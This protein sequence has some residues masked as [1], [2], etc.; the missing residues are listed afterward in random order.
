MPTPMQAFGEVAQ[1]F[2]PNIDPDDDVA[3]KHF[4]EVTAPALPADDR[5]RILNELLDRECV[6]FP[7][8]SDLLTGAIFEQ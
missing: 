5:Q 4:Y 8:D 6:N 3:V 1:L 7:F 2:D